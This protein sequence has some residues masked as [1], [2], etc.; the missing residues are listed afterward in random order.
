MTNMAAPRDFI[1][2][3]QY[4][5]Y[6]ATP[7]TNCIAAIQGGA[8]LRVVA[9]ELTGPRGS[10]AIVEKSPDG[11]LSVD[12]AALHCDAWDYARSKVAERKARKKLQLRG[13]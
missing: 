3:V 12:R 4:R 6:T 9:Y 10:R 13:T 5:G 7:I 11:L 1:A 2:Y 8:E